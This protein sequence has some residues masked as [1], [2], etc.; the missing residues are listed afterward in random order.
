MQI[1]EYRTSPTSVGVLFFRTFLK[2]P[3]LSKF[4]PLFPEVPFGPAFGSVRR[5]ETAHGPMTEAQARREGLRASNGGSPQVKNKKV[6]EIR[7]TCA[8][9]V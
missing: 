8:F 5:S 4:A 2:R 1:A 3:D 7:V 9:L 6:R